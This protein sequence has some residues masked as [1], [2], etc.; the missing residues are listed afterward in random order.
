MP[1]KVIEDL[2]K[3]PDIEV[4]LMMKFFKFIE[5]NA[6]MKTPVKKNDGLHDWVVQ[7]IS[8]IENKAK[9]ASEPLT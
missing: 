7:I 8:D 5:K 1:E 4:K 2:K 6:F 3:I 9:K